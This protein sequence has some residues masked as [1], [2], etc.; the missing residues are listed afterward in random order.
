MTT[1]ALEGV[2]RARLA[3]T[4]AATSLESATQ[5]NSALLVR[6]SEAKARIE[7]A[8]R[9]TKAGGDASG[10]WAMQLRLSTDDQ[11]DIEFLLNQSQTAL[12][13]RSTALSTATAA[14]Q[15]AERDARR[16]EVE[17]HA[18][19]LGGLI[20]ELEAKLCEAIKARVIAHNTLNPPSRFGAQNSCHKLY[21]P[22]RLLKNIVEHAVAE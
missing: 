4:E 5:A 21:T 17:I 7:Q 9:E 2:A 12:N 20:R 13:A 16:E 18:S 1:A 3:Q 15:S 11:A 14:A 10:K 22:S 19:E 8:V 6:L